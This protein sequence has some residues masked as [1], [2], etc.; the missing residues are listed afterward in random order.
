M[1]GG[2]FPPGDTAP[3]AVSEE[4]FNSVCPKERRYYVNISEV[5][6][7]IVWGPVSGVV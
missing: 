1:A 6:E 3:R 2:A 4:F 7:G 5:N